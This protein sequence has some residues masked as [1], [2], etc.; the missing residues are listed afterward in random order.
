MESGRILIG[1]SGYSFPDWV[2]PFY[3]P[4]T[5]SKDFLS[6]Y[7]QHFD[8]VEVNSTYYGIPKPDV[9]A[10]MADKTPEHFRFVVK[11]NQAMTHEQSLDAMTLRSFLEAIEPLKRAGK[12]DGILA[13]FPWA[14]R[15]TDENRRYL[16]ALRAQLEQEPLFV[17]FR[18]D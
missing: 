3:P 8:T 9:L 14:F 6:L 13:Q 7:A 17:E 18:H 10:R 15:R 1:T 11:L 2:G 16:A 12:Y 5:K 4:G